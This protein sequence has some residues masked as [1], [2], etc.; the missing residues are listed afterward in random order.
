MLKNTFLQELPSPDVCVCVP[1]FRGAF[2][3]VKKAVHI[4]SK[5]EFAAKII[6]TR[7]LTARGTEG[8]GGGRGRER[9]RGEKGEGSGGEGGEGRG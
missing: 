1:H 9:G 3:V 8:G 6:N 2:S 5:Q 7:R 4:S